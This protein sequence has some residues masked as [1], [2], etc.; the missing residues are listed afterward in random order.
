MLLLI[1]PL[2]AK[3]SNPEAR[4]LKLSRRKKVRIHFMSMKQN[5]KSADGEWVSDSY[6]FAPLWCP[7]AKIL[8]GAKHGQSNSLDEMP[9]LHDTS[10]FQTFLG[11]S[12]FRS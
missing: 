11:I 6:S 9:A 3:T 2:S 1:D 5:P 10:P 8:S 7:K 4:E 12:V